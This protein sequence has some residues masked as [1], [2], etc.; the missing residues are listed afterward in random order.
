MALH[1][2]DL[3]MTVK[4]EKGDKKGQMMNSKTVEVPD[5]ITKL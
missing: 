2:I 4:A 5:Y 3:K 1:N